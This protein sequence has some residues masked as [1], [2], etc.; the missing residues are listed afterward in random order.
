MQAKSII[1]A[2][3]IALVLTVTYVVV[4]AVA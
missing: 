2:A 1:I 4:N 3:T